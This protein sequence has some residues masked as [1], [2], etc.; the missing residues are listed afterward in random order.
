MWQK[1][2]VSSNTVSF[3]MYLAIISVEQNTREIDE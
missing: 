3:N 1:V 2:N